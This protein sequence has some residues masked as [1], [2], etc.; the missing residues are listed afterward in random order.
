MVFD[1]YINTS[2]F[3]NGEGEFWNQW[4]HAWKTFST[5]PFANAIVFTDETPGV[6]SVTV[7]PATATVTKGSLTLFDVDVAVT[8]FA[9]RSVKWEITGQ[10]NNNTH[11]DQQGR[12]KVALDE[13]ATTITVTA[14]S[15]YD[16][17]KSGTATVTV[18]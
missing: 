1:N 7:T 18:S 10:A 2:D 5:S 16:E 4:Y 3:Y 8:G 9:Y 15:W 6:T 12:L 14:T 13:T 11:I 17:T